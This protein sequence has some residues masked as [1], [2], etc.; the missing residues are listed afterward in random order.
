MGLRNLISGIRLTIPVE[1]I[2]K[3]IAGAFRGPDT[4]V[5]RKGAKYALA[6]EWWIVAGIDEKGI[7]LEPLE[8]TA[9]VVEERRGE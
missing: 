3:A 9:K 8:M 4:I 2:Q 7:R 1:M 5:V 6:G